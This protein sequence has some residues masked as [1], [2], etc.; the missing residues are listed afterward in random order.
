MRPDH[1]TP[2]PSE[3][4]PFFV[5]GN[6]DGPPSAFEFDPFSACHASS[7]RDTSEYFAP[8]VMAS[9]AEAVTLTPDIQ[10]TFS[11]LSASPSAAIESHFYQPLNE[12]SF[13]S[14][15]VNNIPAPFGSSHA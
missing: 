10:P 5:F 7:S 9:R 6:S 11:A 1:R 15:P 13:T 3:G 8:R 4:H 12:H 14:T 2:M